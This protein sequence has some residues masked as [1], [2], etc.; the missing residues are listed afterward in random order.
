MDKVIKSL[1]NTIRL[2]DYTRVEGT[3]TG[4]RSN[5]YIKENNLTPVPD[6]GLYM[7]YH[8]AFGWF[9]LGISLVNMIQRW[10][11]HAGKLTGNVK[12]ITGK[13]ST[14]DTKEF[15]AL[16]EE[17]VARGMDLVEDLYKKVTI[18]FIPMTDKTD[19]DI[20]KAET[21]L[22]LRYP[23]NWRCNSAKRKVFNNL[24]LDFLD[25]TFS[26]TDKLNEISNKLDIIIKSNKKE[27]D[28][29]TI[30]AMKEVA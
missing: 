20:D 25:E 23:G 16:R 13:G 26:K 27:I 12:E 21:G 5:K 24:Q 19:K 17:A 22:L 4:H 11:Q 15:K 10:K 1:Q 8:P 6:R 3:N 14:A 7:L 30:K 28:F 29:N 18:K 2:C 9:Y